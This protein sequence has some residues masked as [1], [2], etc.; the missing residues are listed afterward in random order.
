[1]SKTKEGHST[2]YVILDVCGIN[3]ANIRVGAEICLDCP[4]YKVG[5]ECLLIKGE[6]RN[7]HSDGQ[8]D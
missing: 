8:V 1:M 6:K 3:T 5:L 4:R 7:A 2:G